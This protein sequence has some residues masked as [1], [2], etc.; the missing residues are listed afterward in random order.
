[1]LFVQLMVE[2]V[3]FVAHF[4]QRFF[5]AWCDLVDPAAA[6]TCNFGAGFEHSSSLEAMEQGIQGAWTDA[7]AV[8]G[9]FLHHREAEDRLVRCVDQDVYPDEAGEELLLFH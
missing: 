7:I 9:E 3:D 8:V 6:S 2:F 4:L 5:S 1:M